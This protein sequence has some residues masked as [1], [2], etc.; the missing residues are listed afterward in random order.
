M[1]NSSGSEQGRFDNIDVY[2][3]TEPDTIGQVI[4]CNSS[5]EFNSFPPVFVCLG[6][7]A[8]IDQSVT[9]PDGDALVY[10]LAT[11]YAGTF[12]G[13]TCPGDG[14]PYVPITWSAGYSETNQITGT[15]RID[16][17]TGVITVIPVASV[18]DHRHH[19][20]LPQN[21]RQHSHHSNHKVTLKHMR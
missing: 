1:K 10:S 17:F 8:T 7:S 9:D 15:L 4:T 19:R 2:E 6:D 18:S 11:P 3:Y 16:S 20:L 5:P 14:P 21:N 12:G 13:A